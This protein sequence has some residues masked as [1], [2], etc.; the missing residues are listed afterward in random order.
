MS[1]ETAT[2]LGV[3]SEVGRL[4]TV[5]V[6]R[7]DVAHE[8]LSP[9]NCHDLLFDDVIWVRRARQEFDAFV[10]L[11]RSRGV[12]VLL[13]HDLLAEALDDPEAREFLLSH[14]IRPE[15]VTVMF[16]EAMH[17]WM[18]GMSGDELATH[19]T[20]GVTVQ[21]L[22]DEIHDQIHHALRQTD[23]VLQPLPNHLFTR[24]TSAWI[25]GGVSLNPMYWPA[26]QLETLNC[27][28]IYRF[29]PRFKAADF[30]IWFGG[31]DHDWGLSKMEG[32]DMMPAG[33]G[34]VL[35]GMGERSNARAVSILAKNLFDAGAARLVIGAMMPRERAAMHL[36]TVFTLCNRDVVTIYEPVVSQI[37]PILFTPG[38]PA[39]VQ[40]KESERTFLEEV[41]DALGLERLTV[42]TTGGDEFEA[43]RNQWD[44]GNN[45]VALEPGVI[46]AYERNEATNFKLEKA[47]V[48]VHTIAGSELGRGR[49]GGHCMTCPIVRDP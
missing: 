49:G 32:G 10:D 19:L 45:V 1:V 40:A 6:H 23:F 13:L 12:E 16:A 41:Q 8:R 3:H 14:R 38:G 46:V 15:D 47:G 36:D 18:K 9:T 35:V 17:E 5:M 48:E 34:V 26:R 2:S 43:E 22:P 39:G 4:R 44:D 31:A 37:L 20:G 25:Y 24:D 30:R 7:P 28:T 11:M 29:H 21:E 33:D 27:E 42:V